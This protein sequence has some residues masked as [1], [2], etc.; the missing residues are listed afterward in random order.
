MKK[1]A[2]FA[3]WVKTMVLQHD[4]NVVPD[5]RQTVAVGA[6]VGKGKLGDVVGAVMVGGFVASTVLLS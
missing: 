5:P 6:S 3:P 4:A 2:L 1:G